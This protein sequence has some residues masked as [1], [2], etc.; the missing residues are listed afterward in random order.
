MKKKVLVDVTIS[1]EPP[2][3][4][5]WWLGRRKTMEEIAKEYEHWVKDFHDIIRDHRSQDPVYL[6][7]KRQYQDLCSYCE[8]EWDVDDNGR[9][10][11]C[12]EAMEEWEKEQAVKDEIEGRKRMDMQDQKKAMK[13]NITLESLDDIARKA[14]GLGRELEEKMR[15]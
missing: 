1:C 8:S 6:S 7:V 2:R 14:E 5:Y 9:P 4:S 3:I 12:G 13:E 10:R 11:C 15:R